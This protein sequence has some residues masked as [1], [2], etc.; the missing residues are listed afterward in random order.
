MYCRI[1]YFLS[2][3]ETDFKVNDGQWHTVD[4]SRIDNEGKL[5]F[6]SREVKVQDLGQFSFSNTKIM[7]VSPHLFLG[8][9]FQK[10]QFYIFGF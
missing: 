4:I 3:L 1:I 10:V 8:R 5:V 7:E 6:D 2:R 9:Y